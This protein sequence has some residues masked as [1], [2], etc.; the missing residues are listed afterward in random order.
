LSALRA[1]LPPDEPRLADT[2]ARFADILLTEGKFA[3]V[4]PPARECLAIREKKLPEDWRT[5]NMRS[6]L[7]RGLLGQQKYE[8]A[9]P[10][11]LSGYEGMKQRDLKI[12]FGDKKRL[13]EAIAALVQLY[14]AQARSDQAAEWKRQLED[15]ERT[16]TNRVISATQ[17]TPP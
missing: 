9:Q 13:K 3:E 8:E 12:P 16:H 1:H 10:M 5:Y 6:F 17:L 14:E 15:F 11:L 4:D 7:G 2:L